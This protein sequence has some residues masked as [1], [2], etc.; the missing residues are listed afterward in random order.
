ML[1]IPGGHFPLLAV[2]PLAVHPPFVNTGT[3]FI[4]CEI[5]KVSITITPI[6]PSAAIIAT[7]AKE[8]IMIR[9]IIMLFKGWLATPL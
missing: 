1:V 6:S 5:I 9:Y 8:C 7:I 4:C 2:N 3:A